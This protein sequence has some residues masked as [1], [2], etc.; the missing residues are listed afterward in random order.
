M[1]KMIQIRGVPDDV[2]RVLK[3][4]A[5][6]AGTSLSEL[7]LEELQAMVALPSVEELR[8]RL[9]EAEPFAMRKSSANTIRKDRD[10]A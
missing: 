3:A 6:L 8:H 10:A 9:A 5:A 1:S 7:I 2:H 4:R